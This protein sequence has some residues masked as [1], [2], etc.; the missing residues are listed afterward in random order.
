[1]NSPIC[2]RNSALSQFSHQHNRRGG[3]GVVAAV[4]VVVLIVVTCI[5]GFE[6]INYLNQGERSHA[7]FELST[8]YTTVE[9]GES[10]KIAVQFVPTGYTADD[11]EWSSDDSSI[12][13]VDDSGN[14]T[15]IK[16]G[17]VNIIGSVG[18]H[19]AI[20]KISV[21]TETTAEQ[22]L[23]YN[24]ASN[25]Y[26][27]ASLTG[28]GFTD[29]TLA[30]T[31]NTYG[32]LIV[33]M[34]GCPTNTYQKVIMTI[35]DS[36]GTAVCTHTYDQVS[37]ITPSVLNG[38]SDTVILEWADPQYG[39]Y[40]VIFECYTYQTI[41]NIEVI[42]TEKLEHT[43]TGTFTY[44]DNNG[45]RDTTS[46]V[47]RPYAWTDGGV[48]Y[49]CSVSFPYYDYEIAAVNN[50]F[51]YSTLIQ[52]NY[53]SDSYCQTLAGKNDAVTSLAESLRAEYLTV[54][55]TGASTSDQAYAQYLLTFVQ[56][57]FGYCYD[58]YQYGNQTFADETKNTGL[59]LF[60]LRSSYD[61]WAYSV[62]TIYSGYGDCE[63][64]AILCASLFSAS[65]YSASVLLFDNHAM[66][67]IS[68]AN[69]TAP[70]DY[71]HTAYG[72][73]SDAANGI[74]YY[75]CETTVDS[76]Q[77]IGLVNTDDAESENYCTEDATVYAVKA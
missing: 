32:H 70:T 26:P 38:G 49:T 68:L 5:V 30:L 33:T 18:F 43:V 48:A 46:T 19:S 60:N 69:Y 63:D 76:E 58:E 9:V 35:A 55:G 53:T 74:I 51:S 23:V 50:M 12:A 39:S 41:H 62:E 28:S 45:A 37:M 13:T 16:A 7:E 6:F 67:G 71:D 72:L 64:T 56:M 10:Q 14:V 15:G 52:R 61:Y 20:C 11:V 24:C 36:N 40:S 57:E 54:N 73:R 59:S 1:V 4:L 29:G 21:V 17:T 2:G 47:T 42:G 3:L 34:T 44:A 75:A 25:N 8:T 66:A 65:G 31:F 77:P 22:Y 27:V